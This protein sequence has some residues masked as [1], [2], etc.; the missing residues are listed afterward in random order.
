MADISTETHRNTTD[1]LEAPPYKELRLAVVCY[2]G[3]SLAIYMHGLTKEIHKLVTASRGLERSPQVDPFGGKGTE[4]VY[5]Q[6]LRNLMELQK[7]VRTGVVVDII[8][9]TSAGG[10]NGVFLA[11]S[12]AANLSQDALRD[13]WMDRGDLRELIPSRLPGLW[14]KA[15]AWIVKSAVRKL[16]NRPVSPPL[17]GDRMLVWLAEA[18]D[19]MDGRKDPVRLP[20][21]SSLVPEGETL[22]LFTT[23]TDLAGYTRW[24]WSYSPKQVPDLWHKHVFAFSSDGGPGQFG[25]EYNPALAFAAR[26]TS[27]FPGA[28]PPVS[29]AEAARVLAPRPWPPKFKEEFTR[30][31]ELSNLEIQNVRF[32]DGGVLDNFPFGHALEAIARKPARAE[33]DRRLLF[34]EPDPMV[35]TVQ[36]L[37]GPAQQ[38][39]T[40]S[41][42]GIIGTVWS[43]LST[44]PRHE[45]ILSDLLDI[46]ERNSRIDE[47]Q[48]VVAAAEQEV[49]EEVNRLRKSH[50]PLAGADWAAFNQVNQAITE[51]AAEHAGVSHVTYV[52]VKLRSVVERMGEVANRVCGFPHESNQAEFVRQ[53]IARWA[54]QEG[55]LD[56][57]PKPTKRQLEFVQAFDLHYRERRLR[58]AIKGINICY[59][60]VEERTTPPFRPELDKAKKALWDSV[61]ELQRM[62]LGII[63]G[64]PGAAG[65][66]ADAV[67][68]VFD[69]EAIG[70]ELDPL[71]PDVTDD[72]IARF[73][74]AAR[75]PLSAIRDDLQA[76]LKDQLREFGGKTYSKLIDALEGWEEEMRDRVLV[77]YLGFP[78]WDRLIY[79][80]QKVSDISELNRIE[81]IRLSPNDVKALGNRPARIKLRGIKR[82]HF[83]AFFER[84]WRE[85]DYLWGRLDGAERLLWMLFDAAG[86]ADRAETFYTPAFRAIVGEER[87]SGKLTRIGDMFQKVE[88]VLNGEIAEYPD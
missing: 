28:F 41:M 21:E 61:V 67:R 88:K 32:I 39:E 30:L 51:S 37:Q 6:A 43:G 9:G 50:A 58:F 14:P 13:T 20:E 36:E 77:R 23:A 44:I 52:R 1:R 49:T 18:L 35:P 42:P 87:D 7:G 54:E 85:N 47:I 78:Y 56:V 84:E 74:E 5:W 26:A 80:L 55:Y 65:E 71:S 22:E 31:Y 8:S 62:V 86:D 34:V 64:A 3:V 81:V 60:G 4:S 66:I 70:K 76:H 57:G 19:R 17:S 29:V 72:A 73:A 12:L 11:K 53:V 33:V 25:H 59:D 27:C 48:D 2:G 63:P 38:E 10:I 40:P 75:A 82:G 69:K 16:V 15:A 83:G 45:P 24:V 79:P 68:E 46:R